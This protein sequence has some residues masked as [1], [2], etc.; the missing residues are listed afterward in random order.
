MYAHRTDDYTLPLLTQM[1]RFVGLPFSLWFIWLLG[2]VSKKVNICNCYQ[3]KTNAIN[4]QAEKNE[5]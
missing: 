4:K 1:S 3:A 5:F 2:H